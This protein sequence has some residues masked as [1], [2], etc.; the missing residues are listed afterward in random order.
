[1]HRSLSRRRFLA[2]SAAAAAGLAL[3][4]RRAFAR[5]PADRLGI[6][7][8]GVAGRGGANLDAVSRENVLALCDV[9]ENNLAGAAAR[10]PKAGTFVDY[11]EMLELEGLDAVVVSAPDH[12]HA[13]PA[14]R[15]MK[16]G[17]HVYCEKPLAHTVAEAR[18]MAELASEKGLVTQMGTQIHAGDNYR[19]VVELIRAGA[20]GPVSEVHVWC[21]KTWSGGERPTDRPP[22]PKGLHWDLWLGPAP[23]RPYHSAYHPAG[24]RRWWDFGGG[25]LG[26][27]A[28]HYMDLP[29][30]ALELSAPTSVEATGPPVHPE[31]TPPDLTVR[32]EHPAAGDRPA[33]SLTWYDGRARPEV[34]EELDLQSWGSGVLFIGERGHLVADYGRCVL[35]PES[36]FEGFQRPDPIIPPSI[37]HHAEW[38]E[39]CKNGGSTTCDFQ[40]SGALSEAVLLGNVA[41]R[42]GERI[43]W[44]GAKLRVTNSEKAQ[45]LVSKEVRE[46]WES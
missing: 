32:Y 17:L 21:G 12:S 33:L 8:I 39:A 5:R 16:K 40:Y 36:D 37:G 6:G 26:D 28:C 43:E 7:V 20:I 15:A 4:S 3:P 29:W 27:M 14:I 38:I 10:F 30:W 2:G 25:T 41:Y 11:R 19:R 42:V 1:M 34:L 35:G 18:R 9:D 23:E 31:T 45:A 46:G 24:W 13:P 44:E 22:V